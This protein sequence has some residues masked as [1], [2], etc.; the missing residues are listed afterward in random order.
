MYSSHNS[1]YYTVEDF[2]CKSNLNVRHNKARS[3]KDILVQVP[4]SHLIDKDGFEYS[5]PVMEEDHVYIRIISFSQ[6]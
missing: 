2:N 5:G 3:S 6:V 1:Y 4:K